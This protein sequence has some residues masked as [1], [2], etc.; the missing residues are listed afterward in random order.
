MT[1]EEERKAPRFQTALRWTLLLVLIGLGVL[2]VRFGGDGGWTA[3]RVAESVQQA[4]SWGALAFVVAFAVLQ[5]VGISGHIF[6]LA[7]AAL[8]PPWQATL[9]AWAGAVGSAMVS[10]GLARWVAHDFIRARL[11]ERV[12]RWEARLVD[13][14][15]MAVFVVRLMTFTT[16]PVQYLMGVLP[17]PLGR[18][19]TATAAGFLPMVV[20][21]VWLGGEVLQWL[22]W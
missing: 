5:P 9:L 6:C 10:M 18:V 17:L 15:W 11:P 4:G 19:V 21:D 16:P 12:K 20:V 13:G 8:W 1:A 22:G 14:G 7:A 2:M 3:A